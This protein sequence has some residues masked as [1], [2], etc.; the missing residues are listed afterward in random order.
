[1][2]GS[3]LSLGDPPG[4]GEQKQMDAVERMI[5]R[6]EIAT[7]YFDS[8]LAVMAKYGAA[9]RLTQEQRESSI[10]ELADMVRHDKDGTDLTPV[11]LR[12]VR[13]PKRRGGR[14]T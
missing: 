4:E 14:T 9:P 2:A 10:E 11:K 8:Q 12:K 3:A 6:R 7:E 13:I 1:L 5:R